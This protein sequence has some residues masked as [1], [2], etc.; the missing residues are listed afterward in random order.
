[1]LA[2]PRTLVGLLIVALLA[3]AFAPGTTSHAQELRAAIYVMQRDGAGLRKVAQV[4]GYK[5]H[6]RPAWSHDG[7][8]LAF[9]A[10]ESGSQVKRLFVVNVDGS[11]LKQI[12]ETESPAWSPDDKQIAF[13]FRGDEKNEAGVY[14]Q[15]LDGQGRVR[16]ATGFGPRW[17]PDG[18]RL[19]CTNM[20]NLTV[21]DLLTGEE[22]SLIGE[23]VQQVMPGFDWSPDGKRLAVVIM[24]NR[25]KELWIVEADR[26]N[27]KVEPRLKLNLDQQLS[28]SPDGGRIVISA[29]RKLSVLE[30]DGKGAHRLPDQRGESVEPAWSP[31]GQW[32]AFSGN[33]PEAAKPAP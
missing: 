30:P 26:E 21:L 27:A 33:H 31:D 15:N 22:R 10:L 28:W 16:V 24:R 17:S 3:A 29:D 8:R 19:A 7:K 18:G 9:D 20:R 6:F 32:L 4:D 11:G 23:P 2:H 13:H 5:E 12:G 25:K 14:V 1:M